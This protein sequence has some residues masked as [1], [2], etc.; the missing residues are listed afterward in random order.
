MDRI[1]VAQ[2]RDHWNYFCGEARFKN[3]RMEYSS[4]PHPNLMFLATSPL[5]KIYFHDVLPN[6]N[7]ENS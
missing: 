2:D 7:T 4:I 1:D 6:E 3:I 5:C